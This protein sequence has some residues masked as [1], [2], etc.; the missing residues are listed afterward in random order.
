V[1]PGYVKPF[2]KSQKNDAADAEA[3]CEAIQRPNMRFV[4]VKSVD[5]QAM[6]IL[7]SAR[8]LLMKQ[9][10]MLVNAFRGFLLEFGIVGATGATGLSRL[11]GE[12]RKS[13]VKKLPTSART[14]VTVLM[15]QLQAARTQIRKIDVEIRVWHRSHSESKRLETIPG[16]GFLTATALSAAIPD[17]RQ[18]KS[19]RAL[20]SWLGLVPQQSSSGGKQKLGH[21]TK[22][23]NTRLRSLLVLGARQVIWRA[24]RT[25][26][27]PYAG[28]QELMARKPFWVAVVALANRMARVV[29]ALLMK[30]GTFTSRKLAR[31]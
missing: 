20:S 8:N 28:L 1:S 3:I 5:R 2:V 27:S 7:H 30:G 29:W 17:P 4:P 12:L 10:T 31:A 19:G 24:Q 6:V 16:V 26:K 23:G 18:F 21:I 14:A 22:R 9:H 25:G 15:D 13:S 11:V